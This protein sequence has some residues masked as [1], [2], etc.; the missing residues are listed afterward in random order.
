MNRIFHARI[1]WYHYFLLAVLT[2]N[3]VGALWTK[4]ALLGVLFVLLL[5]VVIEQ[6]IHTTYTLTA[7]GVLLVDKGR[8]SRG[9]RILLSEITSVEQ[10]RSMRFGRFS[11]TRYVLIGYGGG[12]YEALMPVKEREF[13]RLLRSR[14]SGLSSAD[15]HC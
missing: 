10:C 1:A 13:L 7:D 5:I 4:A 6:V 8:F 12:K 9:K 3:A 14:L 11:V 15:I 2:A